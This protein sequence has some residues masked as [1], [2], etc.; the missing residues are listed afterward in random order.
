M[1]YTYTVNAAGYLELS[2]SPDSSVCDALYANTEIGQTSPQ[3]KATVTINRAEGTNDNLA[4]NWTF[5]KEETGTTGDEFRVS[6]STDKTQLYVTIPTN[7]SRSTVKKCTVF[8]KAYLGSDDTTNT[9][10]RVCDYRVSTLALPLMSFDEIK[11]D[12][13]CHADES[14]VVTEKVTEF[15]VDGESTPITLYTKE[16]AKQF[17][18]YR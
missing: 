16:T 4:S 2:V 7:E 12:D 8:V 9:V 5:E 14:T 1:T 10:T 17:A 6:P 3:I 18:A 13:K 11:L 15:I